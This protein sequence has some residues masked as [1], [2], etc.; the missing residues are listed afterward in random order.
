MLGDI[1]S[2][3]EGH[4]HDIKNLAKK[5]AEF[6]SSLASS[7]QSGMTAQA[8]AVGQVREL[9]NKVAESVAQTAAIQA[10]LADTLKRT[11]AM[12]VD[13]TLDALS[14]AIDRLNPI[15]TRFQQPFVLQAVPA[16]RA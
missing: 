4:A 9:A 12:K 15:L 14:A 3:R 13:G 2:E 8:T 11:E 1:R 5:A 10:S 16:P 7:L 6:L